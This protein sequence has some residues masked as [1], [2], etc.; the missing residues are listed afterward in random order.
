MPGR[1]W[2][3]ESTVS[4]T[5]AF[6]LKSAC[7]ALA[8]NSMPLWIRA[9]IFSPTDLAS[10]S[11]A[12]PPFSVSATAAAF[13]AG[14]SWPPAGSSL[15]AA[16][17]PTAL[18]PRPPGREGAREGGR[19]EGGGEDSLP[20]ASLLSSCPA[21]SS[22]SSAQSPC[23]SLSACPRWRL[24]RRLRR[25]CGASSA[26]LRQGGRLAEGSRGRLPAPLPPRSRGAMPMGV[27]CPSMSP[28]PFEG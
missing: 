3:S 25:G 15:R 22:S 13:G 20:P 4:A 27:L 12:S 8:S 19:R 21:S 18:P 5:P 26:A 28:R 24:R 6:V 7:S 14:L 16:P 9:W 1:A 2:R 11:V 23:A 10:P 17:F